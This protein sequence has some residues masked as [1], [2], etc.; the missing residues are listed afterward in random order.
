M[1][2]ASDVAAMGAAPWC[3]LSALELPDAIDDAALD[4]MAEGQRA[5]A[6]RVGAPIVGGNLSRAP[7]VAITTTVLG[8][9]DTAIGRRGARPGDGVWIAGPVGLAAAGLSALEQ[10]LHD[11]RVEPAVVAWRT[12]EAR[13]ADGLAMAGAASAA[14]DISDGLARDLGH[15]ARASGVRVLLDEAALLAHC[16]E[17]LAHA[18]EAVGARPL[19]LALRGGEDYALVVASLKPIPGFSRIGEIVSGDGLAL[20]TAAGTRPIDAA[21]YDHFGG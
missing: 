18:A 1:A 21:G 15:V 10:R 14:I 4:A 12:P 3:A 16:G 6:E 17:T 9:V 8:T 11:P 13:I 2:A 5:A 7:V 19:E 20:V